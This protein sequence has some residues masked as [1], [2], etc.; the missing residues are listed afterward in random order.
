[1]S[2]LPNI[3]STANLISDKEIEKIPFFIGVTGHR[4]IHTQAVDEVQ[5]NV[6]KFFNR[7]KSDFPNSRFIVLSGLAEG[8]DQLVGVSALNADFELWAI[9]P[10]SISEYE[11]DFLQ[12]E[13]LE[14]FRLLLGNSSQI[15]NASALNGCEDNYSS[16]PKIYE[17]LRD[18]LCRMSHSL[19]AVWDGKNDGATGGTSDVVNTFLNG[20]H[21]KSSVSPIS[22]PSC[23]DVFQILAPRAN[24]HPS[25]VKSHWIFA[26]PFQVTD[27]E[28]KNHENN[29]LGRIRY[30]LKFLDQYNLLIT[31]SKNFKSQFP[32]YLLPK[33]Q[34]KSYGSSID[35]LGQWFSAAEK[36]AGQYALKRKYALMFVIVNSLLFSLLILSYGSLIDNT[37]PFI[38][39]SVL[40][41]TVYLFIISNWYKKIDSYFIFCR[42]FAEMLRIAIIWKACGINQC[43]SPVVFNAGIPIDDNLSF[44]AK[45]IDAVSAL[46]SEISSDEKSISIVQHWA[47]SQIEY[48]SGSV[49]KIKY[50]E[51]KSI[52]F[53]KI[54]FY[55]I[56]SAATFYFATFFSDHL[57]LFTSRTE[58]VKFTSWS[59][60]A[61]WT[62]LS[63]GTLSIAYSQV[64][65][66]DDHA[67]DYREALTKFKIAKK[68]SSLSSAARDLAVELGIASLQ[69]ML[70]WVTNKRRH[71]VKLPF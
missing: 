7:L 42:G 3:L 46:N 12:A 48:F 70:H 43:I 28:N 27:Y 30:S 68:S 33:N 1:M 65:G 56:I 58:L 21:S 19:I 51:K 8:A 23:G 9:L 55:C 16:R 45:S 32:H 61:F 5:K 67:I 37:W 34:A 11:K 60:F 2:D 29:F 69:E 53:K 41:G 22:P 35:I 49:N 36:V 62:S 40:L 50:H 47:E 59:M 20:L 54:S 18:Q 38:I 10:T 25:E 6:E 66:H 64:M 13:A 39:G 63:L 26:N 15:L 24:D 17:S 14:N 71:P 52:L 4:N 57:D 44:A 31:N